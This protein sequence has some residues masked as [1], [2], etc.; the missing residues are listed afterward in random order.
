[1]KCVARWSGV[2]ACG[3]VLL[4]T[5]GVVLVPQHRLLAEEGG[6]GIQQC[7]VYMQICD[8]GCA[9]HEPENCGETGVG[10]RVNQNPQSCGGCRCKPEKVTNDQG[11]VVRKV[12]QCK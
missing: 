3:G 1:M 4:L 10:C 5:L 11:D 9:L 7:V 12:C 6:P 8:A 2:L